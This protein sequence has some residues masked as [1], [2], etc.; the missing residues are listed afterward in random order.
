M[1]IDLI[2]NTL[3]KFLI[4]NVKIILKDIIVLIAIEIV[5]MV[6]IVNKKIINHLK[7]FSVKEH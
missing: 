3:I 4:K 2:V 6:K 1:I 5:V 7:I